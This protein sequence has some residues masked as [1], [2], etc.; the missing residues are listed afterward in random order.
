MV[1]KIPNDFFEVWTPDMAYVLGYWWAG[2]NM[3][4]AT[5]GKRVSF[6]SKDRY[7]LEQ[8]ARVIGVGRVTPKGLKYYELAIKRADMYYDLLQLGGTPRKSL[9]ANW[10]APPSE[11]LRHF[12]RGFIDGDGSLYW[13]ST[14]ITTM[15]RLEANGTHAFLTGMALAIQD[16]TGIPVPKCIGYE[17]IWKMVWIGMYAKCLAAWLYEDCDLCLERKRIIAFEFFQWQPKLYRRNHVTPK[18]REF[19][20][21]HLPEQ[22]LTQ[23]TELQETI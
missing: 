19:F 23:S 3:L 8:I 2:G 17:N 5:S 11:I 12:V 13:I 4:Q 10:H 22:Q 21:H 7:Y 20:G 16:A 18:M 15:P 14:V 1:A 9:S 6:T